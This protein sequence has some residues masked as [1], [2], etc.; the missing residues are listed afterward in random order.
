MLG[1]VPPHERMPPRP[2]ALPVAAM[3][4][5]LVP[6]RQLP[7]S[8]P[9]GLRSVRGRPPGRALPG[10][11]EGACGMKERETLT[12]TCGETKW[13]KLVMHDGRELRCT[14][15]P[16]HPGTQRHEAPDPRDE[17]KVLQW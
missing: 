4:E 6:L 15:R 1:T 12:T 13:G 7:L 16:N 10:A 8:T 14:L 9:F 11:P 3:R 17:R 2:A 5:R